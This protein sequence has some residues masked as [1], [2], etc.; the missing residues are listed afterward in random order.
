MFDNSGFGGSSMFDSNHGGHLDA[1]ERDHAECLLHDCDTYDQVMKKEGYYSSSTR[2]R[3]GKSWSQTWEELKIL[4][5]FDVVV[6]V[7]LTLM[8]F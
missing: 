6:T 2:I 7:I 3:G 8:G 4:L 5:F 1:F